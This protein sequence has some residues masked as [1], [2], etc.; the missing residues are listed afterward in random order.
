MTKAQILVVD[1]NP[2][3]RLSAAFVLEDHGFSVLEAENHHYAQQQ[4][5]EHP[6]DLILLDMNFSRDTTSGEEGLDFLAWL[7]KSSF[8]VPVVTMTGWSTIE[9]AVN[10]MRMGA[11]DFIEKPW[12]NE[13]L[14]QI[15]RQQLTLVGLQSQTNWAT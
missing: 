15:I 9:L 6:V 8:S 3:I 1:D 13:R 11:C 14:I 10:A 7:Q 4:L 5:A 2:E 12:N